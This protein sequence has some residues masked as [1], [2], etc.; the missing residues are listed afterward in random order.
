VKFSFWR[1]K[2]QVQL[3]EELQNHLQMAT[4]DRVERG[5]SPEVAARTARRE[6]G[7]V[8][9]I[10]EVTRDQ[11]RWNWLRD[12]L[13]DLRYAA[14]LML[15]SPGFTAV[16]VFTLALG[17]GANTAIFSLI[18]AFLL[19][20]LP[21]KDPQQLVVIRATLPKGGTRGD[22]PFLVFE[23]FRDANSSCSGMFAWDEAS[24]NVTIDGQAQLVRADFV[25]GS[26][27]DVLGVNALFGR[28]INTE[29]DRF[30]SKPVAVISYPYWEERFAR[31]PAAIGKDIYVGK[32][33]FT[34]IGV[35]SPGFTGRS[36]VARP[37]DI[38][39]PLS[40]H[41]QLALGDHDTLHI[42]ARLK[43]NAAPEQA[44]ADLDVLYQSFLR[45][46]AGS[47]LVP[48]AEEKLR[49]Q[50]IEVR[51]DLRG[52]SL[53]SN[54]FAQELR[55]LAAAVGVALLIACVNIAC[56]MLARSS[57][58]QKEMA[59]RIAIGAGRGRLIR[60]L[61]TES[62]LLSCLAGGLGLILARWS[63]NFLLAVLSA[64]PAVIS[65][66]SRMFIFV[67]LVSVATA[68]VFG[69]TPALVGTRVDLN[70]ALKGG[71]ARG[72]SR[73]GQHRV[74]QV[75][76]VSQ[77]ALSLALLISAGL[78]VRSLR[79]LYAVDTGFERSKVLQ[80]WVLPALNGYNHGEEMSL[81]RQLLEKLNQL[82]GV[83]SASLS[84][85][86]MVF[87]RW[88]RDVFVA[89]SAEAPDGAQV[90]CDPAGPHFF[91]TM[92]IP[93]LLGREFSSADTETSSK[94]AIVS[95]SAARKLFPGQNPLGR[96][97]RFDHADSGPEIE[98]VGVVKDIK[99]HIDENGTGEAA[100]IPYTQ[101]PPD[102]YGQMNFLLRSTGEPTSLISSVRAAVQ[103]MDKNLPV[104][105]IGT[106]EAEIDE[107]L[108]DQHSLATLLGSFAGLALALASIGLYGTTS[109]AVARRIRELG[110]RIALGAQRLELLGMVLR[111]TLSLVL[112]G[113][114]IGVPLAIASTRLIS[115]L[116]FTVRGS[117]PLT[118]AA[119]VLVMMAIAA[120][121]SYVP[122]RRAMRVDPML[123]LRYE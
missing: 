45:Q 15:R 67:I 6:F 100:F 50:R 81:Y 60:Q 48:Q 110:I 58:R 99:H 18:D 56:L 46:K 65:L 82:P 5:E 64:G 11:W 27:F 93:L 41:A 96:R 101:A 112:A 1:S 95:E 108:G 9:L 80:F 19:R 21:V 71:E 37:A 44:R 72:E 20:L 107:Y 70:P 30:A 79:F 26:Y 106:Q 90:Y 77:V 109:Y 66:D 23:R 10:G 68:L 116:L 98:I 111:E 8:S 83:Q 76:I 55:I 57:S 16:A 97:F 78:M 121:A 102:E 29:D 14:R 35:T 51:A 117:D 13:Q 28:T 119:A 104:V 34:I 17:I 85:L 94:V 92:G 62:L 87:G 103:S 88:N 91:E 63:T 36:A 33:P 42:M 54:H 74:T 120:V 31:S 73:F 40:V 69:L 39:L 59:V 122:A 24:A 123:A 61:L 118:I 115:S 84:R 25:S 52:A 38:V 43:P 105:A 75:L 4:R 2:Q 86:R 114:I 53:P 47:H 7:N 22:F 3:S 113:V 12:A 32:I 49:R 89:G